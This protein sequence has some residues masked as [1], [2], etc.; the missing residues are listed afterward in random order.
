[1]MSEIETFIRQK[2]LSGEIALPLDIGGEDGGG[3]ENV[4]AAVEE[5][6]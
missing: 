3:G 5:E 6:A 2:A 4:G 1:M